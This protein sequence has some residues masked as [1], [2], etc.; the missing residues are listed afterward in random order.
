MSVRS[1]AKCR[2]ARLGRGAA[3]A[4]VLALA[5]AAQLVSGSATAQVA[6]DNRALGSLKGLKPLFPNANIDPFVVDKAKLNVLGKAL[7]YD[8]RLG[9]DG[10]ACMSC[11]FHAGADI[12]AQNALNPGLLDRRNLANVNLFGGLTDP[13]AGDFRSPAATAGKTGS[14][15]AAGPNI[16]LVT[17]DFP[18]HRLQNVN[19][20]N[21]AILYST[22]D[23]VSSAGVRFG[24]F[25][26]VPDEDDHLDKCT[27]GG[28]GL[29]VWHNLDVRRVEPRNTPTVIGS[30]FFDRLFWDGRAN[31]TGNGVGVFG[32]REILG[33]P[34]A[35]VLVF[36]GS[37]TSLQAVEIKDAPGMSQANGPPRSD[38]EM[39]C[40]HRR[41]ADIGRKM[42]PNRALSLQKV[43]PN[44]S[45]LGPYRHASGVG[46][47]QTYEA[48]IK[49]V[50]ASKYWSA[51]G[52]F[53]I[54]TGGNLVPGAYTQMELNFP[55]FFS[56]AVAAFEGML[57]P[58]DSK[59]D[60]V[61]ERRASFTGVEKRGLD[62]FV[63]QARC[64]N[65]HDG[66]EL[67]KAASHLGPERQENGLVE[68]MIMGDGQVARYDNGFYNIGVT[69]V[70]ADIGLGAEDPFGNPLSFTRQYLD[71][72][73]GKNVPDRFQV[74]P[75]TFAVDPCVPD[76]ALAEGEFLR[77]AVDGA[78]KTP[79]LRN[80]ALTPPYF[81]NGGERSLA[82]VIKF[83][84]RGGNR[85]GPPSNDSTGTGPLGN[86]LDA[87]RA[88]TARG[89][90]LDPDIQPLGL[91]TNDQAALV[92]FLLTLTDNRVACLQAPFDMP[93]LL[94]VTGH[95]NADVDP[96]DGEAD[97][98]L[99]LI[100]ATGRLGRQ[101]EG[102]S[103][104]P[105]AGDLFANGMD[106]LINDAAQRGRLATPDAALGQLIRL[107][108]HRD[109]GS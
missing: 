54:D 102:K 80:V 44:D 37:S 13:A 104:I 38:F 103:C 11:H 18:L 69:P 47:S 49:A 42:L 29:F 68:R 87:A 74:D 63:G 96:A 86:D 57:T 1:G 58:D 27:R 84:N 19:D 67:S 64:V 76:P 26:S 3:A 24:G 70:L 92:A 101:A 97:P 6:P 4:V 105:N 90:N 14:G 21:S 75:C 22:N 41:F 72:L 71:M 33:D 5:A 65:C 8:Q 107:V 45:L 93:E 50:F 56:I 100:P 106:T 59:F 40:A 17:G 91:S 9:S 7:I 30:A 81:H 61:F 16:K 48:L 78:F 35:R 28:D 39:S 20:R 89:S 53:D 51:A 109:K 62:L 10:M 73:R 77:V 85:R 36:D 46:L 25:V 32:R 94:I 12:R 15:Q 83:Y 2:D 79:L 55:L 82:D 98:I 34:A 88:S 43:H 108:A 99:A 23:T 60:R 95:K 66:P 52:T 31:N